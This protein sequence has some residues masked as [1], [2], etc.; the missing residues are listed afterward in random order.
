[1]AAAPKRIPKLTQ[2]ARSGGLAQK[3]T[4]DAAGEQQGDAD[5]AGGQEYG[6][7]PDMPKI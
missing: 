1:M 4:D 3:Q 7:R 5:E 2:R 6:G